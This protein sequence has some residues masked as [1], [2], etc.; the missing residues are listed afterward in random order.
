MSTN[1]IS[2]INAFLKE[3][4]GDNI[5]DVIPHKNNNILVKNLPFNQ[6]EMLGSQYVV[7]V[8][9]ADEQGVTYA[10]PLEDDFTLNGSIANAS[11]RAVVNG[12]QIVIEG[13]MGYK[14]AAAARGKD[15]KAFVAATRYMVE[16]MMK[17]MA[18]RLEIQHLYGGSG[19]AQ[20]DA[21]ANVSVTET[22]ITITDASFAPG[23]WIGSK[24]ALIDVH[25]TAG[26]QVGAAGFTIKS[27]DYAA[28]AITVTG[29][30]ADITALD[31]AF[32]ATLELWFKG[33]RTKESLGLDQII[34]TSGSLFGIDNTVN[35]LWKGQQ[36]AVGGA[37]NFDKI[38]E[39]ANITFNYGNDDKLCALVSPVAFQSLINDEAALREYDKSYSV[40]KAQKGNKALEFNIGGIIIELKQHPMVKQGEAFLVPLAKLKRVG[41]RKESL[42]TP[43]LEGEDIF[44]QKTNST[45][46]EMRAYTD[47]ALFC[48]CP[49]HLVKMTGI[50]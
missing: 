44:R 30:A 10:G 26:V 21:S 3:V 33:A 24:N 50:V 41:A 22:V 40:D 4:Y 14:A 35:D 27:F 5:L 28:K 7:P 11:E 47:Q 23:I 37:L 25:T 43:G 34:T 29:A 42:K 31:A 6:A 36:Y 16:R 39:A 18:K 19:L 49:S 38:T 20:I 1:T 13:S 2:S 45:G 12:S 48:E 17:T 46:Y 15:A 9:L 8:A 32:P